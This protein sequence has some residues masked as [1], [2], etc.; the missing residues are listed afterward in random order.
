MFGSV[1]VL[2]QRPTIVFLIHKHRYMW[3]VAISDSG[4]ADYF[5]TTYLLLM[6]SLSV[7][8]IWSMCVQHQLQRR[9]VAMSLTL[10]A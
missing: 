3:K 8:G 6:P 9:P 10:P 5:L 1:A 4:E 7:L 2:L